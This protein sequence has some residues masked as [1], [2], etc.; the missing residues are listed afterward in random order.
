VQFLLKRPI[1]EHCLHQILAIIE[2][3]FDRN[4][5]HVR[6]IDRRHLPALNLRDPPPRVKHDDLQG[7]P[8]TTGLDRCRSGITGRRADNRQPLVPALEHVFE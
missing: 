8:V 3:T 4:I 2:R 6:G 5:V 7:V 1:V